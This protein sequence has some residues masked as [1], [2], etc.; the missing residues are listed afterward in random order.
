[1]RPLIVASLPVYDTNDL[2]KVKD[3]K[4]DL[5]ELRLDYSTVLP[6]I[7]LLLRYKDKIIVTIRD[8]REGGVNRID[9]QKKI[10]YLRMLYQ[11]DILFDVE[12]SFLEKYDIPYR[13]KIVS[14]HYFDK[15]PEINYVHHIID[16]YQN[17]A[18]TVKVAVIAKDGYKKFLADILFSHRNVTILPMG[19]DPLERI[20]FGILGSK[21]IYTYVDKPTAPGQMKYTKAIEILNA[22]FLDN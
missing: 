15:I 6:E 2:E 7:S 4:S 18:Y 22:L 11:N 14:M 1:M 17:E 3:I 10:E 13:N 5:V 9:D 12:A 21:L 20:A 8:I 16:R 19:S